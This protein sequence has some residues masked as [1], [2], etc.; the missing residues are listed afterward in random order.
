MA[1]RWIV[2]FLTLF[3]A[4]HMAGPSF[5]AAPEE[6]QRAIVSFLDPDPGLSPELPTQADESA[7][8]AS[9]HCSTSCHDHCKGFTRWSFGNL[10]AIRQTPREG[11][12][13]EVRTSLVGALVPP[14]Q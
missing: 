13:A 3:V 5:A 14:P 2:L 4:L 7:Q 6:L 11:P 12:P 8:P 10:S 1:R 9:A